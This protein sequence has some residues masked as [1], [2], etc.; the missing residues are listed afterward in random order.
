MYI[1]NWV[2]SLGGLDGKASTCNAGGPASIPGG[3][4]PLE[5]GTATHSSIPAWRILGE[6]SLAHQGSQRVGR[7]TKAL[8]HNRFVRFLMVFLHRQPVNYRA[9]GLC[10]GPVSLKHDSVLNQPPLFLLG[11]WEPADPVRRSS[12][13]MCKLWVNSHINSADSWVNSCWESIMEV[14]DLFFQAMHFY[15]VCKLTNTLLYSHQIC[16]YKSNTVKNTS[17]VSF[18]DKEIILLESFQPGEIGLTVEPDS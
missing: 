14:Y 3:E 4:G 1:S 17:L 18:P 15:C 10:P 11:P 2:N 12:L 16:Y 5:K 6:R 9:G 7:F 8:A 13:Q